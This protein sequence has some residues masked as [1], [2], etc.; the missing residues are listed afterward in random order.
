MVNETRIRIRLFGPFGLWWDN[1]DEIALRGSKAIALMAMLVTA[2]DHKRSRVWLQ[3][4]LWGR[5]GSEH[6]R[7]SLRQCISA[8]KK[9]LGASAFA[10][11]FQTSNEF[12]QLRSDT[13]STVGSRDDGEFLEGVEIA[14][15]GFTEWLREQRARPHLLANA[16]VA[17]AAPAAPIIPEPR[18]RAE[19]R[20]DRLFPVV[21]VIPFAGMDREGLGDDMGDAIAQDVTRSLS[22]S[23]YIMV[24][25]HLSSRNSQLR[26]AQLHEFKSLL[27]VD[28]VIMGRVRLSNSN[29]RIDVDFIDTAS[30]EL[31]WS[32]NFH[33]NVDHFFEGGDEVVDEMAD[34]IAQAVFSGSLAPLAVERLPNIATHRLM[35]A[36]ITLLHR[37]AKSSFGTARDCLQ[38]VIDRAPNHALP[39]AWFAKW[40]IKSIKQGWS[41]DDVRDLKIAQ[42]SSRRA[43]DCNPVCPFSLS[44]NGFVH[45]HTSRFDEAFRYHEESLAHDP[46]HALAWLLTGVLHTF[47]GEGDAAVKNTEWARKLSPL[48][49]H[50]YFY[51]SMAAGAHAVNGDFE[52]ALL[53]ADRSLR[54]NRRYLST[55][56]VRAYS[57]A[58]L[59]RNKDAER[60]AREIMSIDP[61]F[62][63]AKYK[64]THPARHYD[65]G[66]QWGDVFHRI[67]IPLD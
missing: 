40:H 21:A 60:A 42:E 47:M 38:E 58:M 3:E 13:F 54:V 34:A 39:H 41:D 36:A 31:C 51:D 67:G 6:G 57:L 8:I 35:T 44:I 26:T 7:A 45:H 64:A 49:P 46:N 43:L 66:A 52:S 37:Q 56:R 53:L 25:S 18:P 50:Q 5:S 14:S 2:P 15:E 4:K 63:V 9:L 22:R 62:S 28:Y 10:E 32:R 33:G 61:T 16:P 17:A 59:G 20:Q 12:I 1:G 65:T 24:I 55:M 48:D 29:F 19:S 27:K 11:I 23:P 30:G